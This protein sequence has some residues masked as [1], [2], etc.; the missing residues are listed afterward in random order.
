ML[1]YVQQDQV[2][3]GQDNVDLGQDQEVVGVVVV[4]GAVGD[5]LLLRH[6]SVLIR[7]HV[8]EHLDYQHHHWKL[9]S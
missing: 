4:R 7:V 3:L 6:H 8:G 9:E 1:D 5:E 2:D